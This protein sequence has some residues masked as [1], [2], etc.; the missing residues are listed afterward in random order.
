M[1][2]TAPWNSKPLLLLMLK[3]K[4]K[5]NPKEGGRV[6]LSVYDL[7]GSLMQTIDSGVRQTGL[8]TTVWN[9]RDQKGREVASGTYIVRLIV[10]NRT[11]TKRLALIR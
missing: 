1:Y 10:G 9:G 6:T 7:R 11:L 2:L 4:I 8:H 3:S 5:G